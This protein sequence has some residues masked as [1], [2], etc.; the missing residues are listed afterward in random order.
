MGSID[1]DKLILD[2]DIVQ[3]IGSRV[4]LTPRGHEYYGLC[5]FHVE[6]DPS[7]TISPT[8]KLWYCFGCQQGGSVIDFLMLSEGIG[9]RQAC[10]MLKS[11]HWDALPMGSGRAAIPYVQVP[12]KQVW[13][14]TKPV[15]GCEQPESFA[16][17]GA[18]TPSMVWTYRAEDG[19]VLGYVARYDVE[20]EGK[21]GKFFLQ[22]TYGTDGGDLRWEN[23]HFSRPRPLYGLDR[24]TA[25]PTANVIIVEGEKAADAA[26]TLF[27]LSA[28]VTWPGGSHAARFVDWSPIYGRTVI[29]IPDADEAGRKAAAYIM[30]HLS[31]QR[32]TVKYCDPE[33][34][35][36]KG[37]D[38]ADAMD[39]HWTP[40]QTMEWARGRIRDYVPDTPPLEASAAPEPSTDIVP[41]YA[42]APFSDDAIANLIAKGH[43][44][45]WK[46]TPSLDKWNHWTGTIWEGDTIKMSAVKAMVAKSCRR[47]INVGEGTALTPQQKKSLTSNSTH[48]SIYNC[49]TYTP[50]FVVKESFWESDPMLLGC[51]DGT[52]ELQTGELRSA[53]REDRLTQR[54]IVTPGGDCPTWLAFLKRV[55]NDNM[56]MVAYLQRLCGYCLT[57]YTTEQIL[58]FFYGTGSNGKSVFVDTV[59]TIFGD[60]GT[61]ANADIFMETKHDQHPTG[62]ASLRSARLVVA[63][64]TSEARRWDEAKIKDLTSAKVL[65]ARFMRG[66]FFPFEPKFKLLFTG[67]YKPALRSVDYAIRRRVHIVPFT[68]TITEEEK[69]PFLGQKL[70]LE[71]PGILAWMIRG[72]QIWREE[73][74]HQPDMVKEAT[75]SYMESEDSIKDWLEE[76]CVT[77]DIHTTSIKDIYDNYVQYCE[78]NHEHPCSRKRLSQKLQARGIITVTR[79]FSTRYWKG[80]GLKSVAESRTW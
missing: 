4:S 41:E 76:C 18:R 39:D 70:K 78:D 47:L 27:P 34:T 20:R 66:D 28:V 14:S 75:D 48:V 73:G 49:M 79:T 60:Y 62:V 8:E 37:W 56:E 7:F 5:P 17:H 36:P 50:E 45:D 12:P 31:G 38:M 40:K 72:A 35:R 77:G 63:Q 11:S 59:R 26:H 46:Y 9:F 68:V 80:I 32:C 21:T 15:E 51:P 29:M 30:A 57:G 55:T 54:T 1:R 2:T 71:Y 64:E 53:R 67:N 16:I 44:E 25:R 3:V 10:D 13:R 74:L 33:E 52:V 24:L 61:P 22:W 19:S 69:D 58:A 65:N 42:P 43:S 23:R 6:S